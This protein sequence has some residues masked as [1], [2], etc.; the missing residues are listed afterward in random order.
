MQTYNLGRDFETPF[1]IDEKHKSVSHDHASIIVDGDKWI[2]CDHNSTNGTYVEEDGEF[3]RY[4]RLE[5]TPS[6]WIRLGEQGHRG[7]YFKAR[8]VIHPNDYSEDF[9]ELYVLFQD[10]EATKQRLDNRRKKV[11][12]IITPVLGLIF[13]GFSC[14]PCIAKM[15]GQ[16]I[17]LVIV[18]PSLLSPFIQDI[19][20]NR[21]EKKVKKL[22]RD[23]VCPKCRRMLGKDDIL[24]KEHSLCHAH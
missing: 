22:Q 11:R 1:V 21:L 8:R 2:L 20:L 15:G 10:F 24:N 23:L 4:N 6:T 18:V 5:I 12:Y 14:M 17:R 3:R 16:A 9:E 7:Y 13:L 19:F